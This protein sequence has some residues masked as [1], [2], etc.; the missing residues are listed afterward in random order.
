MATGEIGSLVLAGKTGTGKTH[1]AAAIW[2]ER[3]RMR[4]P[5]A[6]LHLP[7]VTTDVQAWQE[8]LDRMTRSRSR[9]EPSDRPLWLN[10][11]AT[12]VALRMEIGSDDRGTAALLDE[13]ANRRGLVV[14]DDIGQEKAS[15]WTAE[16]I[17]TLV[18]ARYESMLPT[19]V[20]TNL[21]G[22]ELAA[23]PYWPV[24]SRLA[25]DGELVRIEAEDHRLPKRQ[26]ATA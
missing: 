5:V 13:A 11:A 15:D 6:V 16:T 8:A 10:V 4:V 14:L 19:I 17:Y 1:L 21:T 22:A 26:R 20:T 7:P 12:I 9:P 2:L 24:I 25:E 3:E 23:S 18:N